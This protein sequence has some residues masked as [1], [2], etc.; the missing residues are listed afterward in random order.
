M[1]PVRFLLLNQFFWPDVAATSQLLTDLA[2]HLADE[3]HEVRVICA[4][5]SYTRSGYGTLRQVVPA[6]KDCI[7]VVR[8]NGVGFAR[9]STRLLSYA[10]YLA[11]A[12]WHALKGP[13]PDVVVTLT[14]PPLL[15]LVGTLVKQVRGARHFQWEMDLY[16]DV[17]TALGMQSAEW[18]SWLLDWPRRGA[19]G[20]IALGECMAERLRGR[21]IA[22]EK[23]H[24]AENWADGVKIRPRAFPDFGT[25]TVVYSGNLGRAHEVETVAGAV[26]RLDGRFRLVVAGDGVGRRELERAGAGTRGGAMV[27]FEGYCGY[28]ELGERLGRGHI[29]LVTQKRET[30]GCVVPSKVYGILAAGR[31]VL[32]V[33]PAEATPTRI[34]ERFRCGWHIEPGDVDGLVALLELLK[35]HPEE[36]VAAGRRARA[37]FEEHYDRPIG[38]VRIC[39]ILGL[40]VG[41]D[42]LVRAA[43]G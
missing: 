21:G 32:F 39:G 17:A 2:R 30:L 4:R 23:I 9:R 26:P 8:V 16:P 41:R 35:G 34:V 22:A 13:P 27:T 40:K 5:S 20:V 1:G 38:V 43:G 15:G 10:T 25:L 3:G 33:G 29:G 36:V 24:V 28:E 19:V 14:T 42:V 6:R 37:A 18:A 11:G 31:P 12:F 7:E